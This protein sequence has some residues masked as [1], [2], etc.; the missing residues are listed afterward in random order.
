MF[1]VQT[2]VEISMST[3][4]YSIG[5]SAFHVNAAHCVFVHVSYHNNIFLKTLHAGSFYL[6]R[7]NENLHSLAPGPSAKQPGLQLHYVGHTA[8]T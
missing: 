4:C 7:R 3:A 8:I 6:L 1:K 5:S 2:W